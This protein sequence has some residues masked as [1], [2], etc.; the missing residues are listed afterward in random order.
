MVV[1]KSGPDAKFEIKLSSLDAG[2]YSFGIWS[3]DDN[4]L[5]STTQTFNISITYGVTTVISGIFLSPTISVD[6]IEVKKGDI[7]NFLGKTAPQAQISL[8]INS[9]TE[10]MKKVVA[11]DS[12][13]WF[14]KFDTLEIDKG[15]HSGRSRATQA[16]DMSPFSQLVFFKVGDKNV[17]SPPIKKCPERADLNSDCRVDLVDF[18]IAAYWWKRPLS[19]SFAVIE[20]DKLNGDGTIDLVDFSIM[21]YYWT[22]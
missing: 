10:V 22:G 15:D 18:S 14:Y 7:L 4:G 9:D 12:G 8:V 2:T 6:K 13:V 5:R 11:N 20:K 17:I 19:S 16:D 3:D 21:A 1:T